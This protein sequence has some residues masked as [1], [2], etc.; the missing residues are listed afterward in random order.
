MNGITHKQAKRHMHADLDGL[1]NAHQR[2]DL[3][4]HLRECDAC[5]AESESLAS[6]T[7]RLQSEFHNRWDKQNG[8]STNVMAN[9]HSQTRRIML[10]N[11]IN[12]GLRAVGGV[13]AFLVIIFL[14]NSVIQKVK[15]QSTTTATQAP[16]TGQSSSIA[17]D[18]FNGEW[19]AFI[20]G[21]YVSQ[22]NEKLEVYMIH[23]DG[24]GLINLTNSPAN[25]YALQ[26]SP[27]GDNFI[28]LQTSDNTEIMGA[29]QNGAYLIT[30]TN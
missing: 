1:L 11:R 25:Y 24:S 30:D 20:S 19:I 21:E 9:V 13:A 4:T 12:T 28:F 27:N 14:F 29:N 23:P 10:M 15:V 2:F 18:K 7:A 3:H 26:W 16:V 17:T 22:G 6:L 8:P 5:R